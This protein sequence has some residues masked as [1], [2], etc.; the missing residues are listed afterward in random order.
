MMNL[1][2]NDSPKK[3]WLSQLRNDS[4]KNKL[5]SQ[6]QMMNAEFNIKKKSDKKEHSKRSEIT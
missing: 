1:K 2:T 5:L 4:L 3:K 6:K